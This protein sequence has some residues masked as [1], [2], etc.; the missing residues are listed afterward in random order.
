MCETFLISVGD[1]GC[2]RFIFQAEASW[3]SAEQQSGVICVIFMWIYEAEKHWGLNINL[4]LCSV[5]QPEGHLGGT[6]LGPLPGSSVNGQAPKQ[7]INIL[8]STWPWPV[9]HSVDA[10]VGSMVAPSVSA[11]LGPGVPPS[12]GGPTQ[13][14][15]CSRRACWS[16][17]AKL[18]S[19][20]K[21]LIKAGWRC[22]WRAISL[23]GG[24]VRL[25]GGGAPNSQHCW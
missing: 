16:S 14:P 23:L 5:V 2:Q 9:D 4:H 21:Q 11:R 25:A 15:L 24:T 7:P 12:L 10:K 22:G 6:T 8:L 19:L 17:V 13:G 3:H 20:W 1:V 18:M